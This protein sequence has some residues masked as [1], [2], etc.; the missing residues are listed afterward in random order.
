M[1]EPFAIRPCIHCPTLSPLFHCC[2][3][4]SIDILLT[5]K[6]ASKGHVDANGF[7]S[8]WLL[9]YA[10]KV[11][12]K[13]GNNAKHVLC[14]FCVCFGRD[15]EQNTDSQQNAKK[16]ERARTD[17]NKLFAASADGKWRSDYF[18]N[19][20]RSQ[21]PARWEVYKVLKPDDKKKYLADKELPEILD[22]RSFFH[23]EAGSKARKLADQ[24][25]EFNI[26][27][28]V[29]DDLIVSLLFDID[30]ALEDEDP[31]A[32]EVRKA[33]KKALEIFDWNAATKVYH[34]IV[35]NIL[36]MNLVVSFVS[37]GQSFRQVDK[38]FA[39]VRKH[40]EC[41]N[42]G[43]M[44]EKRVAIICRKVCTI[45]LQCLKE[46]FK[47]IWAFSIGFDAANHAKSSYLDVRMRCFFQGE[48]HNLHLMAIPMRERHTGEYQFDLVVSLLN[49]LAPNWRHQLMGVTT[50]GAANM[51]GRISGTVTRLSNEVHSH[52][53]RIWCGAHQLDLVVKKALRN[54]CRD[55]FLGI[56]KGVTSHLRKQQNLI[57]DMNKQAAKSFV[58]TRWISMGPALKWLTE[59]E[60]RLLVHFE[61][62]KPACTPPQEFWILISIISPLVKRI[63]QTFTAI[64]GQKTLVS[65]QREALETLCH[66]LMTQTRVKLPLNNEDQLE[67]DAI[68]LEV[69]SDDDS[70]DD[71]D[72]GTKIKGYTKGSYYV[73]VDGTIDAIDEIGGLQVQFKMDL[74]Q[75]GSSSDK[76]VFD[77][78]VETTSMFALELVHGI[79]EV[80][81]ER[82][83]QNVAS[84][85]LPPV[86]PLEICSMTSREFSRSLLLQK[87]RLMQRFTEQEFYEIDA[88]YR[89]LACRFKEDEKFRIQLQ[90]DATEIS[91]QEKFTKSWQNVGICFEMLQEYCG[92][93]ASVM[94]GTASVESDFSL[95]NWTKDSN[96]SS[97]T[98]FTLESILH[99][100]QYEKLLKMAR[101]K[102]SVTIPSRNP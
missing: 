90:G 76:T 94:A 23:A 69:D 4:S 58:E 82:D 28:D 15:E 95:I 84:F 27:K 45:N 55:D 10:L 89:R 54:L 72:N 48:L 83:A 51:T 36:Q 33:K 5:N 73:L 98:D 32:F 11:A 87:P 20:H 99:C 49:I 29:I 18:V 44:N 1:H 74:L 19:H 46:L 21:H 62:K 34:L 80:V 68:C 67:Y 78:I 40:M 88:Q 41:G 75:N 16:R 85:Q 57:Q 3:F 97:M 71:I 31:V 53:F 12:T 42:L 65:E 100:K 30:T 47:N 86:L 96:S 37:T 26:D 39:A 102:R 92:G 101:A 13:D 9:K 25:Y 6:M 81:V 63:E 14:L 79:R 38:S 52:I 77:S 56:L 60:E 35:P 59:N 61:E 2:H 8:N 7:Q 64:Q 50:D 91:L 24:N 93:L 70:T 22:M 66:S 43:I 17:Y